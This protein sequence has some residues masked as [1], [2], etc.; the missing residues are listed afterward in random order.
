LSRDQ[1]DDRAV[2]YYSTRA[3]R[4]P[5]WHARQLREARERERRA[6]ELDP[7]GFRARRRRIDA[8]YRERHAAHGLTFHE[9]CERCLQDGYPDAEQTLR[10]VLR[11]ELER[12]VLDYNTTT[13]RYS[14]NGALPA[15]VRDALLDLRL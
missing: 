6:R 1:S 2:S 15:D 11:E 5:E 14:L 12:G 3:Q 13:R 8:A 7:E 10:R 9:L 4:D